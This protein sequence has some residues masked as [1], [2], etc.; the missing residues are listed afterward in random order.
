MRYTPQGV[1]V[2]QF[3]L[4]VDRP[5][6]NAQKEKE[7]DYINIVVW[8]QLAELCAQYLRKGR[9]AAV[10]GRLQ[11]RNYDNNEGKRVYVTEVVADN[12]R[13]LEFANAGNRDEAAGFTPSAPRA[14]TPK[15]NDPFQDDGKPVD[16]SDDDLP[17]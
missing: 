1:A 16:L 3:A 8:R 11:I 13:F 5:Y 4:A 15:V 12:V 6:S 2:A 17:F 9:L 7:V 14:A 10:E